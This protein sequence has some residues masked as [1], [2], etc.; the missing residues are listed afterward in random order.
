M[1]QDEHAVGPSFIVGLLN[2]FSLFDGR[3]F[4]KM[5]PHMEL[6]GLVREGPVIPH[7]L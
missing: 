3:H 7:F 1:V 2:L 4:S 5:I 6:R